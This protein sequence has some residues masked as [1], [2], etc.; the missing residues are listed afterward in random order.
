MTLITV[1]VHNRDVVQMLIDNKIES[2]SEFARQAQMRYDWN[3]D[4]LKCSVLVADWVGRYCFEYIGN[5]GRLVITPLTDRCYITLTQA[6]RLMMGGAPAGP[7]G[8]GKT[9]TTKDFRKSHG[10]SSICI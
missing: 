7:A 5:T 10:H 4:H 1:D 9:E 2:S 6:L 8:T 3:P